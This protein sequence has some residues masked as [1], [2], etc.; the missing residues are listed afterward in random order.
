MRFCGVLEPD[1]LTRVKN[2]FSTGEVMGAVV[3]SLVG[4]VA[5]L[6]IIGFLYVSIIG[7]LAH[8]GR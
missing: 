6:A 7:N 5:L 4:V 1:E 8:V 2:R 3:G